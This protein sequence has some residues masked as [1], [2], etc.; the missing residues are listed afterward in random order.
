MYTIVE[1]QEYLQNLTNSKITYTEIGKGLNTGR[2]NISL[3]A[4]NSS[5]LSVSEVKRLEKYFNLDILNKINNVTGNNLID[6]FVDL[7][8]RGEVYASMGSGVTVYNENQ[9]GI[10]KVNP[11][12][13]NDIGASQK[14]SE[15]IFAQ[16]DSML[17]TIEG[18]DSLIVDLS[19]K[20]IHDGKIYV[21]RIN[22]ELYAKRL[23]FLPPHTV[24]VISDN[25]KYK[26]FEVDL[27]KEV[28]YDFAVIGE[29]KYWGRVAR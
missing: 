28:D 2:S 6:N 19:K 22:G 27:S 26:S 24:V 14:H 29:V 12:L 25:Q 3:R 1:I 9:T 5:E 23:Q 21:V 15:V 13:L 20:D 17:P 16:G 4:K 18:G 10:Y 7:P 8:V 11:Q